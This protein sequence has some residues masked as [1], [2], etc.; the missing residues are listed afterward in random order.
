VHTGGLGVEKVSSAD[1][2]VLAGAH[3]RLVYKT[4]GNYT[5]DLAM[6]GYVRK[7][8]LTSEVPTDTSGHA[9]FTGVGYGTYGTNASSSS[10]EYWIV[11]TQA[12]TGFLVAEQPGVVVIDAQSYRP[13]Y[14][15][16]RLADD[17]KPQIPFGAGLSDPNASKTGDEF[18]LAGYRIMTLAALAGIMLTIA[19]YRRK[20]RNREILCRY[21]IDNFVTD[22]KER[23]Q[24][25]K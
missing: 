6:N 3:F 7:N 23:K 8:G 1:G 22:V 16:Y 18:P 11:E 20:S 13:G 24:V 5:N 10:S 2:R 25:T 9:V 14:Y 19:I 15:K 21:I 4:S 12:P 17:P